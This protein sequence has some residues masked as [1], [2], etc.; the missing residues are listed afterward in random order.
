MFAQLHP[1]DN[2]VVSLRGSL[3]GDVWSDGSGTVTAAEPIAAGHKMAIRDIAPGD[4]VIKYG[5]PIGLAKEAISVGHKVHEHNLRTGLDAG[6][7]FSS[8]WSPPPVVPLTP[9]KHS[10]QAGLGTFFGYER[11][12]GQVAI[13][14]EIWILNTVGCVNQTGQQLAAWANRTLVGRVP[15]LDGVYAYSHPYGCSQLGDDLDA[16]RAILAGLARHPHA[17]GVLFLGLG[18][19]NN[20]MQR[21]LEAIGPAALHKVRWFSTQ[22]VSDEMAQG[23]EWL[24]AMA[25]DVS[26]YERRPIPANRLV[27]G[28][29]CGGSDGFSGITAN[30]LLGRIADWH[31]S[32]G[33]TTQLTEIPEMFGAE[34]VL[35]GRCDQP[36]TRTAV[37]HMIESFKDYFRRHE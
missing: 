15:N 2:V 1:Q 11:E 5:L 8:E 9:P 6:G 33:G 10:D 32:Q 21:Q 25:E 20:Q 19:E 30:P 27:L 3:I 34:P 23:R 14:N 35:L 36:E 4:W 16:T 17:A 31:C 26:R 37:D 18:C 12:D 28:M 29:K 24:T 13:R 7:Q 22:D